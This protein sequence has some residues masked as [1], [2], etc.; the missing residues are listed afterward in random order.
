MAD[1][2]QKSFSR[3]ANYFKMEDISGDSYT[4]LLWLCD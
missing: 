4:A 3:M 2:T 1:A